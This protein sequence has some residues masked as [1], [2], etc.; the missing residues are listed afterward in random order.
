MKAYVKLLGTLPKYYPGDYPEC[1]LEVEIW[2][3]IT[4]TE[5]VELVQISKE[6]IAIVSINGL[7]AKAGD[8]IPDGAQVKLIQTLSGG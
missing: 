5:L 1:G 4:V 2:Q 6:R 8:E 3:R 7:L